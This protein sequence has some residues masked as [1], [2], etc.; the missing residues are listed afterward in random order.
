MLV[1][2]VATALV[3]ALH[4]GLSPLGGSTT[5]LFMV[6][7][8]LMGR[9]Q[10]VE[11]FQTRSAAP[12]W[13]TLGRILPPYLVFLAV[14]VGARLALGLPVHWSVLTLTTNFVD[15]AEVRASGEKGH[16]VTLW[17]VDCLL[18]ML[19]ALALV[20]AANLRWRLVEDPRRFA[21]ALLAVGA[22]LRFAVSP[23]LDPDY[24][25]VGIVGDGALA[26]L[27]TTHLGTLAL[28]VCIAQVRTRRERVRMALVVAAFATGY[29]L[30]G[31]PHGWIMLLLFGALLL[32]VPRLPIPKGLHVV[33][34]ML[35]GS[36]LFIYLTHIQ[37]AGVLQRLGGPFGS[38]RVWALALASGVLL[39]LAW[40]RL[41]DWRLR[42]GEVVLRG[43][44]RVWRNLRWT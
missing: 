23:L 32:F 44:A 26:H 22:V 4:L 30:T 16:N 38:V 18:Q 9:L 12:F 14:Y 3:V 15:I 37:V 17:Y 21:L 39:W 20:M 19:A 2:A 43:A 13:R 25:R 1:R 41:A 42:S 34:L 33:V 28:G 36:S 31:G 8:F 7:G 40:Q 24:L 35:S 27:P 5:A 6:S 10:L 29:A 11:A